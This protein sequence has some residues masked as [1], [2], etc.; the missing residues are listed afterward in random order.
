MLD[1]RGSGSEGF[2]G[3]DHHVAK[4]HRACDYANMFT[5]E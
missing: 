1:E 3:T 2:K 5:A 4:D